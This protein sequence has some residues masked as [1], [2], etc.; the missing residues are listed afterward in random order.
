MSAHQWRGLI[1]EYGQHTGHDD[2]LREVV[3]GCVGEEPG[4]GCELE[5]SSPPGGGGQ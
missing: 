1:E 3:D 2:L 5:R 4:P